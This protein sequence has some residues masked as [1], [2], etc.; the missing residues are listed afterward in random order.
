ML[1]PPYSYCILLVKPTSH[2]GL[3][4]FW[5]W[6]FVYT[7]SRLWQFPTPRRDVLCL[8]PHQND[9]IIIKT[10]PKSP[11]RHPHNGRVYLK[12]DEDPAWIR[13]ADENCLSWSTQKCWLAYIAKIHRPRAP[14]VVKKRRLISLSKV[15]WIFKEVRADPKDQQLLSIKGLIPR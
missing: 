1:L 9:V 5:L 3:D 6:N 10:N 14:K 13:R 12:Q 11:P 7:Q 2:L 8:E 4:I 15:E